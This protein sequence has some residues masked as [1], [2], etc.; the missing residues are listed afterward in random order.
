MRRLILC[1]MLFTISCTAN[2]PPG[3]SRIVSLESGKDIRVYSITRF[4]F[5]DE[6]RPPS[7]V[8]RYETELEPKD[9]PELRAEVLEVWEILKPLAD[10]AHDTYAMVAANEPIR[11]IISRTKSFTYEFIRSYDGLWEMSDPTE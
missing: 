4:T 11:G 8:L 10:S 2:Q 1:I 6:S 3:R 5:L 7:L 9:S